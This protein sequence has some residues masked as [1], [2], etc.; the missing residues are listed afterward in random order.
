MPGLQSPPSL[1][2]DLLSRSFTT[3]NITFAGKDAIFA[4]A[5]SGGGSSGVSDVNAISGAVQIQSIDG[6]V[7]ITESGQDIDLAVQFP[8]TITTSVNGLDG[9]VILESPGNTITFV[10]GGQNIGIDINTSAVVANITVGGTMLQDVVTFQSSGGT[11]LFTT[12]TPNTLNFESVAVAGVNT[13]NGVAGALALTSPNSTVAIAVN[14]QN[15]EL[16]TVSGGPANILSGTDISITATEPILSISPATIEIK[17]SGGSEGNIQ[18]QSDAGGIG[19]NGGEISIEA[20]GGTGVGGLYGQIF[21]TAQPG[22]DS[23]TGIT[24]GGLL[25]LSAE[26]GLAVGALCSVVRTTGAIVQSIAGAIPAIPSAIPGFN[27]IYGNQGISMTAGLPAVLPQVPFTIYQYA[28][29]GISLDSDVYTNQ[30][31]PYWDGLGAVPDLTISGRILPS[32]SYVVLDKVKSIAMDSTAAITGVVSINGAAY[33]PAAPAAFV[34]SFQIYVCPNGT[35]GGSGSQQKPVQTI[36]QAVLLRAS[37][38]T[39]TEVSII[40][41]SGTYTESPTLI[42]NTYLVGVTTGEARQPVNIT[43]VITYSDSTGTCGASGLDLTGSITVTSGLTL[44]IFG[45]NI[46]SASTAITSL[47]A[48]LIITESRISIG[49]GIA[50]NASTINGSL[51]MRDCI[52]TTPGSNSCIQ[53]SVPTIIR[54]CFFT[55]TTAISNVAALIR[56]NNTTTVSSEISFSRLEYTSATVDAAGNKC[57]VQFAGS[58]INNSSMFSNLFL[59]PGAVTGAPQEQ[60]VQDIGAGAVNL[61]YGQLMGGVAHHIAPTVTKTAFNTTP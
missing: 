14:G 7:L 45:C 10:Q 41:S 39:A 57:C 8:A 13:L 19:Q 52:V 50:I 35:G 4:L 3:P 28:S 17:A 16:E 25:S 5:G 18:I 1:G 44:N 37:I 36:A 56:F 11:V 55:S 48:T 38:S 6:S 2:V 12:S 15:I 34:D 58:G 9:A 29:A 21:I 26:T 46:A 22:T 49:G 20:L 40:L 33:P 27:T 31:Y 54:Q 43:G 53:S 60:S 42:R 59:C 30:M 47:G 23:L 24:T 51:T 32:P 61:S